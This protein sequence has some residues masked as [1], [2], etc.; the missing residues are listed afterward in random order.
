LAFLLFQLLFTEVHAE[1]SSLPLPPSPVHFQCPT[2]S[3]VCWFPV[4]CLF[5]FV[6]VGWV[7]LPR[8]LCWF[9]PWVAGGIPHDAWCSPIWSA[10]C[11]PSRFGI[12]VLQQW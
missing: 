8:W 3:A 12:S 1:I 10:K 2:P 11:L 4:L 6:L 5:S 7:S 9:I